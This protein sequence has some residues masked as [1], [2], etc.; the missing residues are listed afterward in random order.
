M[1]GLHFVDRFTHNVNIQ[2]SQPPISFGAYQIKPG[3]RFVGSMNLVFNP[4]SLGEIT[5]Q[6]TDPSVPP[7][8][9]PKFMTHP[10][11]R[12]VMVEA[13]RYAKSII[14]AP[15]FADKISQWVGPHSDTDEAIWVRALIAKDRSSFS[16]MNDAGLGP[17]QHT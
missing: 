2:Y 3:E 16:Q 4:Q 17:E 5:L 7:L 1:I 9:D 13:I 15:I 8:I 10:Y 12:R 6:S 11:D 14:S